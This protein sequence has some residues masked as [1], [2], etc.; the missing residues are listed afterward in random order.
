MKS[1]IGIVVMLMVLTVLANAQ[2]QFTEGTIVYDVTVKT[3]SNEPQS[4]DLL[5]GAT[6]KVFLKGNM[7]RTEMTSL[8]GSSTTIHDAKNGTA[9]RL[10]EYGDQKIMTKLTKENFIESNKKYAGVVFEKSA[11]VKTIAGYKCNKAT[12]KLKDGTT[13]T[14]FYTTELIPMNKEYDLQFKGLP[15]LAL[16]YE[17][18]LGGLQV[19]FTASKINFDIVPA[20]RFDAPKSGYREMTYEESRGIK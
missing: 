18:T 16:E 4:A 13:F 3:G 12:G 11:E 19:T 9:I 5:D 17:A 1:R 8:L 10:N 14:V 20:S 6:Q 2:K 15:G 7:S